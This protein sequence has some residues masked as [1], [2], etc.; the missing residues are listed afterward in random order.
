MTVLRLCT[1]RRRQCASVLVAFAC[2][3]FLAGCGI[4]EPGADA[5]ARASAPVREHLASKPHGIPTAYGAGSDAGAPGAFVK[6]SL[7]TGSAGE[8]DT[9]DLELLGTMTGSG[10]RFAVI[11]TDHGT[12]TVHEGDAVG[13]AR[14]VAIRAD[15]VEMHAERSGRHRVL[16]LD[17]PGAHAQDLSATD[18][19]PDPGAVIQRV[20]TDQSLPEHPV[21][22]PTASL[23]AG[24]RQ[25]GH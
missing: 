3:C 16:R 24:V 13:D 21:H 20:N 8:E 10:D 22:G 4:G 9:A 18:A 2:A 1:D 17:A 19:A 12:L 11:R 14:I 15:A 6:T 23:P 7:A 25:V 5:A